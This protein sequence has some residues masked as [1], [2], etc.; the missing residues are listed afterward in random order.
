MK[1]VCAQTR[2]EF[3]PRTP[4][5]GLGRLPLRAWGFLTWDV[6]TADRKAKSGPNSQAG[7]IRHGEDPIEERIPQVQ[8]LGAHPC[9]IEGQF[10]VDG[11]GEGVLVEVASP[12][13]CRAATHS[14]QFPYGVQ[15]AAKYLQT[16]RALGLFKD[17]FVSSAGRTAGLKAG[18]LAGL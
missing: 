2:A 7:A 15:Q 17:V 10:I 16:A 11:R 4:F 14:L 13:S 1:A 8:Q 5:F 6:R 3:S 9:I 12:S 18:R